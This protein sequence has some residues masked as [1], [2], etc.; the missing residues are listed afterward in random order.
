MGNG[1]TLWSISV[2]HCSGSHHYSYYLMDMW[3]GRHMWTAA[4]SLPDES[5]LFCY[6]QNILHSTGHYIYCWDFPG[7]WLRCTT[8][9]Q[10]T[11]WTERRL[12]DS[13]VKVRLF[14][15]WPVV[16]LSN[17]SMLSCLFFLAWWIIMWYIGSMTC[18]SNYLHMTQG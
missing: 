9:L 4:M 8:T 1:S 2:S 3:M 15:C 17:T 13:V 11:Y 5:S 6:N 14:I 16:M 12:F 7:W 10:S 18:S